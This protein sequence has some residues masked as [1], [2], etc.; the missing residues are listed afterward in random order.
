MAALILSEVI[1]NA[2]GGL[3][4]IWFREIYQCLAEV[5]TSRRGLDDPALLLKQR[6]QSIAVEFND[7]EIIIILLADAYNM[8]CIFD[9]NANNYSRM[10]ITWDCKI[11]L[12]E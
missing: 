9:T 5:V 6:F 1:I 10:R 7:E 12:F 8:N 2:I 3:V 4:M 11:Y